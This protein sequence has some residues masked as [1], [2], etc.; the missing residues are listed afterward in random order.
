MDAFNA[1]WLQCILC[2]LRGWANTKPLSSSR[3][4]FHMRRPRSGV[5]GGFGRCGHFAAGFGR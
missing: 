5:I 4:H 3:L 1:S 2:K